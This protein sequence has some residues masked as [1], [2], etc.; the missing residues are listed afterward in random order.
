MKKIYFSAA[1]Q[2]RKGVSP[3]VG[4]EFEKIDGYSYDEYKKDFQFAAER[5]FGKAII[6]AFGEITKRDFDKKTNI[7]LMAL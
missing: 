6:I 7:N 3:V 5:Y 1:I 4:A 2:I